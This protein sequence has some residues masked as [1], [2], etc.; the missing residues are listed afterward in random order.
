MATR[1]RKAEARGQTAP[2]TAPRT[3]RRWVGAAAIAIAFWLLIEI[4]GPALNGPF[5]FDDL[6]LPFANPGL[7]EA[8]L[9]YWL[10]HIRPV[11]MFT[12]WL[13]YR[14][15]GM[16]PYLYHLFSILAHF[17]SGVFVWLLTRGLLERAGLEPVRRML[18]AA[19]VALVFLWHPLQTESVAYIAGRSEVLSGLFY[20]AALAVFVWRSRPAVTWATSAAVLALYAAAVL[21]KEHAA[22]LV[23]LLLLTDLY[24]NS[25][26]Q[27]VRRNW[28]LYLPIAAAAVA[29]A[30]FVWSVLATSDTAGFRVREFAW[31]E[32]FF[33]Q[34]RAL[35]LYFRLFLLP[36]GQNLDYDFPASRTLLEHGALWGLLGLLLLGAFIVVG[37]RRFPLASYGLAC[38]LLTLAPTSSIVPL[39]DPVAERR[40]YLAVPWLALALVEPLNRWRASTPRLAG[41][42]VVWLALLGFAAWKRNH[43]WSDEIALWQDTVAKSPRKQ[44]PRFQLAFAYY[45]QGRCR[46][47]LAEF[48]HAARLGP[49]DYRLLV[50]W[51]LAADCAGRPEEA[52]EKLRAAAR[53]ENT[54]HV[55]ALMGM[56]LGKQ[57]RAEE[58]LKALDLAASI[59]PNY[60]MTYVYRGNVRLSAGQRE[61]AIAD[62]RRALELDPRN[63]AARQA[64]ER[65]LAAPVKP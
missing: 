6:Y 37:R 25:G 7:Q 5:L 62:Y 38:A 16:E 2:R 47:A 17:L 46:E 34:C 29:A 21:S 4:Y 48:E 18:F 41:A 52:L 59:D 9:R 14:L 55:H 32:Y 58:A 65:A 53:L 30:R 24:W 51:A 28:R 23:A 40:M 31:Y 45:E 50:D 49:T 15:A 44:R 8:P 42:L 3:S 20:F 10:G 11:L 39:A 35:W 43:V 1:S 56:V 63:P 19:F 12:Y 27:G 26:W 36:Y 60:A 13:N 64:L 61:A 22:S 57:G 54:A 33:T